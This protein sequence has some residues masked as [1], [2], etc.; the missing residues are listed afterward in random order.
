MLIDNIAFNNGLL[1]P[2][3]IMEEV[4][5]PFYSLAVREIKRYADIPVFFHSDGNLNAAMDRIAGFGFDGIQSLQPSA[6][7]DIAFIKRQYGK[8]LCLMGNL[9]LDYVMTRAR[10]EEVWDTV[11]QTIEATAEGGGFIFSTC[12]T[13]I[14]AIPE[15]NARA[16]Y[17]AA[18][19]YGIYKNH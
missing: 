10:P 12:N 15:A 5:Y 6:G 13:L 8:D 18:D 1:L 17:E 3:K 2:P 9:D 7:M 16:M 11:R 14:N 4:A 19:E